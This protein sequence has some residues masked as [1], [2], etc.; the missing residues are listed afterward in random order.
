MRIKKRNPNSMS[1]EEH[2]REL[3]RRSMLV[4]FTFIAAT[5]FLL[6]LCPN[7]L[8]WFLVLGRDI[9]YQFIYISPQELL[10]QHLRIV[11]T[12]AACITA[13]VLLF[14]VSAFVSPALEVKHTTLKLLGIEATVLVMFGLGGIF[15]YKVLLP[16]VYG[17]LY[18]FGSGSSITAQITVENYLSLFLRIVFIISAAFELPLVCVFLCRIGLL[19]ASGMKKHRRIVIVL[20]FLIS[21]I[22]TPP[23]VVS[24]CLVAIPLLV[25][26]EISILLC[27]ITQRRGHV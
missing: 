13:P 22:I 16:F 10:L 17:Y 7:C 14:E 1:T 8:E 9:G 26:Y 12:M 20:V 24:Q 23:D 3:K 2:F 18:A 11:L 19:K 6:I 21:A 27:R 15:A 25:L 4:V 5:I